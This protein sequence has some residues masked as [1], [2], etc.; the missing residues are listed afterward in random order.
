MGL[1][2]ERM[3]GVHW[4]ASVAFA[5]CVSG[6]LC[7]FTWPTNWTPDRSPIVGTDIKKVQTEGE[8]SVMRVDLH[9]DETRVLW[10]GSASHQLE[11]V[12]IMFAGEPCHYWLN[13]GAMTRDEENFRAPGT[14]KLECWQLRRRNLPECKGKST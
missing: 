7:G 11:P 9:K 8:T 6:L 2:R 14:W 12:V 3:G 5:L 1:G 13:V 4:R 10:M